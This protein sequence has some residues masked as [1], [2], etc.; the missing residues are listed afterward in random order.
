[1]DVYFDCP[2]ITNNV[3]SVVLPYVPTGSTDSYGITGQ[4]THDHDNLYIKTETTGWREIPYNNSFGYFFDT[5]TQ[6]NPTASF[7]NLFN[8]NSTQFAKNV[9]IVDNN[10]IYVNYDGV[11]SF[12]FSAQI[13]KDDS[14]V[15]D[16]DIWLKYN[17]SNVDNSNTRVTITGNN[18]RTVASWSIIQQMTASSYCQIAWSSPDT[19]IE[20]YSIATQS[21]P[22]RPLT[23]SIT[24]TVD[25]ISS[26]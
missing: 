25:K 10:K 22:T 13:N 4:L 11:Y 19:H 18:T 9:N 21:S 8:Y 20:I 3:S 6:L 5:T 16:I 15:D 26:Y 7:E 17:G 24:L 2:L 23:P 1:M 14:G 12:N